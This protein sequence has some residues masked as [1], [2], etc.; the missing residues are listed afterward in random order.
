MYLLMFMC[1][2]THTHIHA[3]KSVISVLAR[4]CPPGRYNAVRE[5]KNGFYV[6]STIML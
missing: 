3:R 1:A 4:G 6:Y 2:H 5:P